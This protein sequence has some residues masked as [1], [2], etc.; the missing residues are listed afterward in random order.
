MYIAPFRTEIKD[1]KLGSNYITKEELK[2]SFLFNKCDS[3]QDVSII[4][5]VK[6]CDKYNQHTCNNKVFGT[7]ILCRFHRFNV[8]FN[9][10]KKWNTSKLL[11]DVI[12]MLNNDGLERRR[13]GGSS[14]CITYS[15]NLLKLL[16][17]H[18]ST[19][20]MSKGKNKFT[21]KSCMKLLLILL[22]T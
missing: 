18:N 6:S 14:G 7:L 5:G 13:S 1:K 11:N 2:D 4:I 10:R 16:R 15:Q 22:T 3:T 8:E 19:P 21:Y 9:N 17:S 20:R 12:S